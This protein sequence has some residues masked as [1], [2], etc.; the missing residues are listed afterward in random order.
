MHTHHGSAHS[1]DISFL[2]GLAKSVSG[3]A[4]PT[5]EEIFEKEKI[6]QLDA[7]VLENYEATNSAD[8]VMYSNQ[9]R[10]IVKNLLE[11]GTK[12]PVYFLDVAVKSDHER[13][14]FY[15]GAFGSMFMISGGTLAIFAA[16]RRHHTRKKQLL[17]EEIGRV[18][19]DHKDDVS[20]FRQ[21]YKDMAQEYDALRKENTGSIAQLDLK[22]RM[23]RLEEEIRLSELDHAASMRQYES[24]PAKETLGRRDFS[25]RQMLK[26]LGLGGV[27]AGLGLYMLGG[28]LAWPYWLGFH[29][30]KANEFARKMIYWETELFKS[31]TVNLRNAIWAKKLEEIVAP[32]LAKKLG[33]KPKIAVISGV[34]HAG[35]KE[36][37]QDTDEREAILQR[38]EHDLMKI[39]RKDLESVLELWPQKGILG[40]VAWRSELLRRDFWA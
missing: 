26:V 22:L 36:Y 29:R 21:E 23:R 8:A 31:T 40:A 4:Y 14:L 11:S 25:R 9:Y 24:L 20:F 37:L 18:V 35:L 19:E 16:V 7:I 6:G 33:R 34:M 2:G 39:D 3:Q 28:H 38:Y 13:S 5:M 1:N 27:Y 30:G 32:R 17:Q 12:V 10:L 15:V